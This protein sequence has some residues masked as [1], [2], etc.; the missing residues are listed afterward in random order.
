M[1]NS[2]GSLNMADIMK[3]CT[4]SGPNYVEWKRRVD[5][6]MGFYG[7]GSCIETE[8]PTEPNEESV[9]SD[10]ISYNKWIEANNKMKYFMLGYMIDSL[11]VSYMN[12]PSAKSI[13]DSLEVKFGKKSSAHVEGLWEK[14]IRTKL[15]EGEDARQHVINM[16]ALADELALQGRLIDEKTKIS[17]ILSSLPYSYDTLRQIY[18]VLGLDWKLDDL[19]SKVTAQKDAKLRVKEFSVNVVE[20]K[21]F[22]PQGS[23]RFEK[24]RKFKNGRSDWKNNKR[25]YV[26]QDVE[27]K[28][29]Q[30]I[31]YHCK[32][33]GHKRSEC[34]SLLRSHEKQPQG[35]FGNLILNEINTTII[36]FGSWWA[37]SGATAHIS[38]TMQGFKE[39]QKISDEASYI[40]MGNDAKAKIEGIGVFELKLNNGST[41]DL[42]DCLYAPSLRRNLLAVSMLEKLGYDFYFGNGRFLMKNNGVVVLHGFRNNNMYQI[43]LCGSIVCNVII[44]MKDNKTY[45]WHL[46]LGHVGKQK[47][48]NMIKMGLL[49]DVV[50]EDFPTCESCIEGKMIKKILPYRRENFSSIGASSY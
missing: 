28:T 13:I 38:N 6:Y 9:E 35:N 19:L 48:G 41:F 50:S 5:L 4:L 44:S 33:L 40:Y 23:K 18:F 27:V 46:R 3:N 25:A 42:V 7:Y 15:S 47:I 22:V 37:D 45:L 12:Y 2:S 14:F 24:K 36:E 11:M 49:T 31:C 39:I 21:G 8:C 32:K 30:I 10:K 34:H 1:A 29:K 17:T 26:R 20:Q 16:I 43:Q